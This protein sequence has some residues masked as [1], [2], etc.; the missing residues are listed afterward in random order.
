MSGEDSKL[1]VVLLE[2]CAGTTSVK[3]NDVLF[4]GSPEEPSANIVYFGG[5]LQDFKTEMTKYSEG[6]EY[7]QWNLKSTARLLHN[8]FSS[9]SRWPNP[10]IWVI[11]PSHWVRQSFAAYTNFL[12]FDERTVPRIGHDLTRFSALEQ[13]NRV[14]HSAVAQMHNTHIDYR[15]H[16]RAPLCLIGFSK[17]CCVLIQMLYELAY[18]AYFARELDTSTGPSRS[19]QELLSRLDSIYWL[20]GGHAG[21]D[22]QWPTASNILSRLNPTRTPKMYIYGTSYQL[23]N[24]HKPWKSRDY[25]RFLEILRHHNFPHKHG[26][27]ST[28]SDDS[29]YTEPSLHSHFELLRQFPIENSI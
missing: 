14:L 4:T 11:R 19:T 1:P 17:G 20:D 6:C 8:R 24:P 12:P 9:L 7:V 26:I 29:R 25:H 22:N 28:A 5:D 23:M 18:C 2:K 21:L 27:L 13:L 15:T 3:C 16:L 10:H